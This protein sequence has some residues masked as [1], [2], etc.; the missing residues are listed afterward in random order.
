MTLAA[1]VLTSTLAGA[2]MET[3]FVTVSG[4]VQDVRDA[5][6]ELESIESARPVSADDEASPLELV[7][8]GRTIASSLADHGGVLR[9]V[10]AVGD[11]TRLVVEAPKD[12]DVRS[13]VERLGESYPRTE[14]VA[15]RE[16]ERPVRSRQGFRA[17]LRE[18]LTDRQR[19]ALE[20]AYYGGFFEWPRERTGEEVAQSLGVSQ[21]TFN[22][23]Y[24][25]AERNL[26][27]LLFDEREPDDESSTSP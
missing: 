14:L 12:V 7:V 19:Q 2:P 27:G 15:R 22:R 9:S 3:I 16:R 24:R 26:F 21:P 17:A 8:A 5:A 18:R 20:A 10:S 6:D 4:N 23:H 13:F 25:A 1:F 11:R